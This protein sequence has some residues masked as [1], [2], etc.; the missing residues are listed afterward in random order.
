ML[1]EAPQHQILLALAM[2]DLEA[3]ESHQV[4]KREMNRAKTPPKWRKIHSQLDRAAAAIAH[5]N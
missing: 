3:L 5:L 4:F 2:L 1:K